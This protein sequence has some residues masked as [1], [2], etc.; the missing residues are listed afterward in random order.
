[1]KVNIGQIKVASRIR[2]EILHIEDL[3]E[4]IQQNGLLNPVTVMQSGGEFQLL[5]GLRRLR[6]AQL[7]GWEEIDVNVVAAKDAEEALRIEISENE[8]REP[9]TTSERVAFGLLLEEIEKA[10]AHER[11]LAGKADPLLARAGGVGNTRDI[12]GAKIGMG[13]HTYQRAKFVVEH[14]SPEVIEQ[15]DH[16]EKSIFGAYKELRAEL[17][18]PPSVPEK[19]PEPEPS[20]PEKHVPIDV[21]VPIVAPRPPV[22]MPK[23]PPPLPPLPAPPPNLS[24]R[25]RTIRAEQ[26]LDAMRYRQHNEIFHRDSIIENLKQRIAELEA[27][28]EAANARIAELE[29]QNEA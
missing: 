14:A 6:A 9:F 16:G 7:L 4:D 25:D 12:V 26:E 15:V 27:E 29:A 23:E 13:G 10:K 1:M 5:A 2:K 21:V 8:Q 3:A 17:K 18:P 28:L 11:S 20:E 24:D 19:S 22:A